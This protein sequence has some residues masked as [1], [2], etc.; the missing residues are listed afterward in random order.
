VLGDILRGVEGEP[1]HAFALQRL[2]QLSAMELSCNWSRGAASGC[3][4][5]LMMAV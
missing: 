1:V 2:H 4:D 5:S 3:S